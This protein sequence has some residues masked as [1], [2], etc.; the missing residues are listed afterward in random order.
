MHPSDARSIR[1]TADAR[2]G[3]RRGATGSIILAVIAMLAIAIGLV[4]VFGGGPD[5]GQNRT[6]LDMFTVRKGSFDIS[7]PATG[8]L[9]A[10]RQV[11]VASRLEVRSVITEIVPEGASVKAGDVLIRLDDEEILNKIKD[12]KVEIDNADARLA[13]ARADLKIKKDAEASE[14]ALADVE[15]QLADLALKAWESGEDVSQRQTLALELEMAQ[16]DYDRLVARHEASKELLRQE[17]ISKDEFDR[18]EIEMIR[19]RSN[20]E[21]ATLDLKVYEEFLSIQK[22]AELESEVKKAKDKRS[23]LAARFASEIESL[24]RD[25]SN[26]DFVLSNAEED[27]EKATRQLDLCTITAPEGGMIVYASS[28]QNS[29]WNRGNDNPPPTIGTELRRNR[30]VMYIPDMSQMAAEVK[31]NEALSGRIEPGQRA[32]LYSDATPD[33]PIAGEVLGVGVLAETGG[34]RD[35]NRRDYTVKIKLTGTEGLPLKPSM[36]CKAEIF[37]GRVED[38]I[39]IPVQ[40]VFRTGATA[41]A[42]VPEAS[43]YRQ[44]P[45]TIGRTSNLYVEILDGLTEG[46]RILLR[47]PSADEITTRIESEERQG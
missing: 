39:H 12:V 45:V 35:P 34:W 3:V 40:G 27:F 38:A 46:D 42:Y 5:E 2:A 44:Q 18:D 32:I 23:E 15:I 43:G 17:F 21:E 36:R 47:E 11:E 25:V 41:F 24:T 37:V 6:A 33:E 30:A 9:S 1:R 13:A 26:K 16:K 7:I 4:V 20:L 31:V 8:E 22:R 14:L 10:L 28:M 29:S 19:A